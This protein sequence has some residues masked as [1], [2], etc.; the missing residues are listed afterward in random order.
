M[1]KELRLVLVLTLICAV[2][3]GVLSMVDG[4]T[5]PRIAA[6]AEEALKQALSFSLPGTER[7]EP[8]RSALDAVKGITP[9]VTEI[10]RGFNGQELTG[11]VFVVGAA[12]Y[13][14]TIQQM[15]G[16][17]FNGEVQRVIV[18]SQA[19]TPGLGTKVAEAE[20]IDQPAIRQGKAGQ[21]L[22]VDRDGGNVQAATGATISSRAAVRGINQ[23]LEAF[24]MIS[25]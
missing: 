18:L 19:E 3:A 8:D 5:Q 17:N 15:V 10:Y 2:A 23:A 16:I 4:F 12:G 24:G 14:S 22:A 20:F 6:R 25:R 11:F 21:P 9:G 7:F 1:P 13:S